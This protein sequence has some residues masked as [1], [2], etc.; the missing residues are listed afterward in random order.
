MKEAAKVEDYGKEEDEH[1]NSDYGHR[2]TAGDRTVEG[3]TPEL[4]GDVHLEECTLYYYLISH[5]SL[6]DLYNLLEQP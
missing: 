6:V 4:S 3:P 1:R 2:V 5:L